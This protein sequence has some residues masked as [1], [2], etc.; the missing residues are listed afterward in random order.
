MQLDQAVQLVGRPALGEEGRA[1]DNDA[2]LR[3]QE[4]VINTAAK[5]VSRPKRELVVPRAQ[6]LASRA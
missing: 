6:A 4:P 3:G 1:Q 2:R 5:A